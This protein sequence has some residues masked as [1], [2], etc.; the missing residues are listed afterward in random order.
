MVKREIDPKIANEIR[1]AL[2]ELREQLEGQ[3]KA[4][5]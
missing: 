2:A 1:K 5:C 3:K 4:K